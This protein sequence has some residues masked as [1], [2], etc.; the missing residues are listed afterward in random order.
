MFDVFTHQHKL[1]GRGAPKPE[2]VRRFLSVVG[3]P[4]RTALKLTMAQ[5]LGFPEIRIPGIIASM[6]R[7]LNVVRIRRVGDIDQPSG[8][9]RLNLN[10]LKGAIRTSGWSSSD[11]SATETRDH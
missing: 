6:R 1:A 11:Q 3:D 4:N 5:Q 2:E 9:I 10:L 8:T 7:I